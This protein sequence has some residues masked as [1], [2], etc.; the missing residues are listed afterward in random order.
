MEVGR[1]GVPRGT[2]D[3]PS[4]DPTTYLIAVEDTAGE[5]VGLVRVW[6]NP[7]EPRL[8][9]IAVLPPYRRRGLATALLARAFV[10]LHNRRKTHVSAESDETNVAST[11]LLESLGGCCTG[12]SIEV[13]RRLTA[14]SPRA[15]SHRGSDAALLAT[16][17]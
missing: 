14:S 12:G 3:S 7:K 2:F 1:G 17:E 6:D 16:Q 8:G 13:V 5:Y 9:M 15:Q 11:S 10:A 4:F